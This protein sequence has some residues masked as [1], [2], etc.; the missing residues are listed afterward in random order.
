M[1]RRLRWSLV[2]VV[3][4]LAAGPVSGASAAAPPW[5]G[6]PETD[7]AANLPDGSSPSHPPG[8]FP[9]IPYYAIRCTLD[10]IASRSDGRMTVEVIGQSALGRDQFGV[11][12]NDLSTRRQ[13]RNYAQVA[14]IGQAQVPAP[15]P[16]V[17]EAKA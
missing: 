10:D 3:L 1:V 4:A 16:Q 13:R 14:G 12:I 5:C 8:S 17:R 9:H 2:L 6:T 11:V 15:Q 7:A